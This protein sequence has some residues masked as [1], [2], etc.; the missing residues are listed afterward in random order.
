MAAASA[1]MAGT[2]CGK[3]ASGA[4]PAAVWPKA[5]T[6]A[7]R[8]ATARPR[9]A[10][11]ASISNKLPDLKIPD[12]STMTQ[13]EFGCNGRK[14]SGRKRV[15]N[16]HQ[17]VDPEPGEILR[18]GEGLFRDDLIEDFGRGLGGADF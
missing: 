12:T 15:I 8:S 13:S 18:C 6:A 14:A 5:A 7:E 2:V 4:E 1:A 11:K 9:R 16:F 17:E 10:G 3:A